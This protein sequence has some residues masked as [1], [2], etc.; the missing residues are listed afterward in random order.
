MWLVA[1]L[2][3]QAIVGVL[4]AS[5][6][7]AA[8]INAIVP[9][10]AFNVCWLIGTI[11]SAT[12]PVAVVALL[13]E[14]GTDK[15]IGTLIEGE[16]LLNDG[17]AVVLY[18]VL[19]N[20]IEHTNSGTLPFDAQLAYPGTWIDLL[21]IVMQMLVL[22]ILWG[23]LWGWGLARMLRSVY[24]DTV[25]EISL[26]IG[27]S[28]LCFWIAEMFLSSSAV[29]A[30]VVMGFYLNHHRASAI[31][32]EVLH[33]MHEFYEIIAWMFNTVIF[34]IAGYKLGTLFGLFTLQGD[35]SI[36][37]WLLLYPGVLL[38][39]GISI[40]VLYP[41]LKRLGLGL[42]WKTAVVMWW[43]GLRGSVGLALALM[44]Y[45]TM[46]SNRAWGGP[47]VELDDG[48]LP[49]RDIPRDTLFVN[50]IIV[51]LT[52]VINGSTVGKLLH[53]LGMD[54]VPEDRRFMLN[55]AARKLAIH[56]EHHIKE[57]KASS[58]LFGVNW[59]LVEKNLV[60]VTDSHP[61][62]DLHH[63]L[64]AAWQEAL[65][66][67]R[68]SYTEQFESGELGSHAS[69]RLESI[70]SVTQ[71]CVNSIANGINEQS[72][73]SIEYARATQQIVEQFQIPV[74]ATKVEKVPFEFLRKIAMR[75]IVEHLKVAY[76]MGAAFLRAHEAMMHVA[77]ERTKQLEKEVESLE[78]DSVVMEAQETTKSRTKTS[79]VGFKFLNKRGSTSPDDVDAGG[80]ALHPPPLASS[81]SLESSSNGSGA[82]GPSLRA[83][84][85]S[86]L[87]MLVS[88]A[89]AA[90]EGHGQRD[91]AGDGAAG[92]KG[93]S[94]WKASS[95]L[96]SKLNRLH[97]VVSEAMDSATLM[98]RRRILRSDEHPLKQVLLLQKAS[99]KK[100]EEAMKELRLRSP[101]I[102]RVVQNLHATNVA[103]FTQRREINHMRM[104]GELA[105]A[106][107]S[108]FNNEVNH[109][110]KA[111]YHRPMAD[112]GVSEEQLAH[113]RTAKV[114]QQQRKN[115][116][117][118]RAAVN[119]TAAMRHS[120]AEAE[121]RDSVATADAPAVDQLRHSVDHLHEKE[122]DKLVLE[123][124]RE[125]RA[126]KRAMRNELGTLKSLHA[127]LPKGPPKHQSFLM[128]RGSLKNSLPS[129]GGLSAAL[130]AMGAGTPSPAV[131][132]ERAPSAGSPDKGMLAARFGSA[133]GK[134][135]ITDADMSC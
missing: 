7:T 47:M 119:L 3:V 36:L 133:P 33:T 117:K 111:L 135:T 44:V 112:W 5:L 15:A 21:R 122:A 106:D 54:R 13:K 118:L 65:N 30:V 10:W 25:I 60:Q 109:K 48:S 29:I 67:E 74:W 61:E 26:T 92:K 9:E 18:V 1:P 6:L 128:R 124:D 110:L 8:L 71:A 32:P 103:L 28:Y 19:K 80:T 52:V 37:K 16:S 116:G 58:H 31:S 104:L 22:G 98:E 11:T 59:K 77:D 121:A 115:V 108:A 24:N 132:R 127:H 41:L 45:H 94:S 46:Y 102:S 101:L 84:R 120:Q 20:W 50:C 123:A 89:V 130:N 125:A 86:S 113:R 57:M 56:T 91:S 70:M 100:I 17:S 83:V 97:N 99:V 114:I 39:R 51:L 88:A 95:A 35:P 134:T 96:V 72:T 131:A 53:M 23:L 75:A 27:C 68:M 82:G 85:R 66:I 62:Y 2:G 90:E 69:A 87:K 42:D 43:G 40:S 126:L 38:T 64:I 14:L 105:D 12:D 63:P 81:N 4:V 34:F 73:P 78:R 79:K 55:A 76:E 93:K 107:A 49:C 129:A